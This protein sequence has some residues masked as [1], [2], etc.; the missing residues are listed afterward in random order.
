MTEA[1]RKR[2][3]QLL[4]S[5]ALKAVAD[6]QRARASMAEWGDLK[7]GAARDGAPEGMI[8]AAARDADPDGTILGDTPA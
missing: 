8:V 2:Y 4:R 6:H 5:A 7:A 3:R 1:A